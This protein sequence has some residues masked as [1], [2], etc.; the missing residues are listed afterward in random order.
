MLGP[1]DKIEM[2]NME[3]IKSTTQIAN[4]HL[5]LIIESTTLKLVI[6]TMNPVGMGGCTIL[7]YHRAEYFFILW[8][9]QRFTIEHPTQNIF[10]QFFCSINI[11]LA[12]I[13]T[14]TFY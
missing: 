12:P 5:R 11:I 6:V 10:R 3:Q 4:L 2:T 9:I 14:S 13:K 1:T 8:D 7:V